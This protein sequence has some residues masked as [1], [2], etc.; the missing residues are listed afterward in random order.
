[1]TKFISAND[2]SS[3]LQPNDSLLIGGF[4]CCGSPDEILFSIRNRFDSTGDKLE[5]R[6]IFISGVGNG[7]GKG[8]DYLAVDGLVKSAIGG[9]WGFIPKLSDM[10]LNGKIEAHNW[11][12]GVMTQW[13]KAISKGEKGLLSSIGNGTFIDPEYDGGVLNKHTSSLLHQHLVE[14]EKKIFFPSVHIDWAILRG[15]RADLH[16]N[17][18]LDNEGL[19]ASTIS[20]AIAAQ[21][22]RGRVVVQVKE[23][24]DKI[25]PDRV[26]IP[27]FLVDYVCVSKYP[28]KHTEC[29]EVKKQSTE[30]CLNTKKIDLAKKVVSEIKNQDKILNFG[31]GI[32]AIIPSFMDRF[33]EG[34]PATIESGVI[35]GIPNHASFGIA[36]NPIAIINPINMF[37]IYYGIGIDVA[38]LGFAEIDSKCRV[39]VS[40]FKSNLRGCGG[41]IDIINSAKKIIF[42][43]LSKSSSG[44]P[45][46]VD[47]VEHVTIDLLHEQFSEKEILIITENGKFT[48]SPQGLIS[49]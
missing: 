34:F 4:G 21:R 37:D 32:P 33:Q 49:I 24:V 15:S 35:G 17:I 28:Q 20:D 38:V 27:G 2:F 41:F 1:M 23:I 6:L 48:I 14:G 19:Y 5:L 9:F 3:M 36:D 8:I 43:G 44:N 18:S 22:F 30:K 46:F 25:E 10:A 13:I 47:D 42:C 12:L 39:N 40:K 26:T 29:Y 45:K 11:P 16:G 7:D 31:I